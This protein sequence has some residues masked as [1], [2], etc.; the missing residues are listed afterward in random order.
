LPPDYTAP[1]VFAGTLHGDGHVITEGR[2]FRKNKGN[3]YN[4]GYVNG[5]IARTNEG[6]YH[7]C[8]ESKYQKVYDID[9][10]DVP[11]TADDFKYGRVAYDLNQYNMKKAAN[12]DSYTYVEDYYRNGDFQYARIA[13]D[14]LG[15]T[16]GVT[17]LRK[18]NEVAANQSVPYYHKKGYTAH[19]MKHTADVRSKG[20]YCEPLFESKGMNDYRYF[21]QNLQAEPALYP[22]TITSHNVTA[23][24]NRVWRTDGYYG[25]KQADKFYYN[26]AIHNDSYMDTYVLNPKTTAVNFNVSDDNASVFHGFGTADEVTRNLLVYTAKND[27]SKANEAVDVVSKSLAYTNETPEGAIRGHHVIYNN[28]AWK[29]SMLHLVDKQ[30]FN[31]PI[32]FSVTGRS[33]YVRNP[34]TE[35]GYVEKVGYAWESICLPF[36]VKKSILS[37]GIQMYKE[38]DGSADKF[39]NEITFFYG[40][41]AANTTVAN[42]NNTLRHHYWFRE[43]EAVEGNQATFS[44]PTKAISD[45]G[46]AANT[47]Y[48]VSFPGSRYYEF[49]M[50]GQTITFEKTKNASIAVTDDA[51]AA[52]TTGKPYHVAFTNEEASASK[53]A[54]AIGETGD[55]QGMKFEKNQP[56]YAFRGYMSQGNVIGAK[57]N[58][59]TLDDDVIYISTDIRNIE[60]LDENENTTDVAG[61]YL[62]VYDAGN[63]AIGVE[64]SYDTKLTIYTSAGQIARILDVRAGTSKY[65]GFASGIYIIGQKKLSVK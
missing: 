14:Y 20:D 59:L 6:K 44:R 48:I 47:P 38:S 15:V 11:Y 50:T 43:L 28:D 63:H 61:E 31:A 3:I 65:S 49:D 58:S 64:S 35:T 34:E 45:G 33:W 16:T 36:E 51:V 56:I 27:K 29:A 17:Y 40:E 1:D 21:G 57:A 24:L 26:A 8:F 37:D 32:E 18:G 46:F 53:Y 60:S 10:N 9:G 52:A 25:N 19:N 7:C 5:Q 42:N 2:L 41:P 22:S 39:I 30:T 12:V 55:S 62:R 54:I 23:A 4:L 13:D